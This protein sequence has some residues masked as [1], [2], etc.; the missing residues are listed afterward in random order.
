MKADDA[1]SEVRREGAN[2]W[3]RN[4]ALSR[5][6]RQQTPK[7]A[8]TLVMWRLRQHTALFKGLAGEFPA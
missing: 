3:L 5:L 8:E 6:N 2:E 7:T 1:E 4:T